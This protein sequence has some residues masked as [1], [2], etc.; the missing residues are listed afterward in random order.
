MEDRLSKIKLSNYLIIGFIIISIIFLI[1]NKKEKD[2]LLNQTNKDD[3]LIHNLRIIALLLALIIYIIFLK[4]R[5]DKYK[6]EKSFINNL[7]I[8]AAI[9]FIIAGSIS[10]YIEYKN[11]K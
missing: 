5:Y 6:L 10:L 7:D 11:V 3:K 8:L 4:T 1:A 2:N 9:I